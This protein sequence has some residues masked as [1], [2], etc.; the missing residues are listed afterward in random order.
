[1]RAYHRDEARE[2]LWP[3]LLER[4]YATPVDADQFGPFLER[5]QKANRDVH[6]R[7]GLA[8]IRVWTREDVDTLRRR[9][10]LAEAI[11]DA[12]SRILEALNDPALPPGGAARAKARVAATA[13]AQKRRN[14]EGTPGDAES[15]GGPS[16]SV[17]VP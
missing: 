11:R 17:A 7:P 2:E 12:P 14:S 13:V 4:G 16:R 1:M 10:A 8:L 9:G 5:V 3:W 15:A 6:L